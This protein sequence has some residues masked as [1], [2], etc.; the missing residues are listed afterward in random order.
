MRLKN[1]V[2]HPDPGAIP[3]YTTQN[4]IFEIRGHSPD[5]G[6]EQ[7]SCP[8]DDLARNMSTAELQA[9]VDEDE[10][11]VG[12]KKNSNTHSLQM[13]QRVKANELTSY[14]QFPMQKHK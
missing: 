12:N 3:C 14:V 4:P 13:C 10:L 5:V 2:P 9:V 7:F 1:V 6:P 11:N 8:I